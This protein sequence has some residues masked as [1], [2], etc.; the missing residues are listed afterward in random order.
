MVKGTAKIPPVLHIRFDGA[1]FSPETFYKSKDIERISVW[2]SVANFFLSFENHFVLNC[3]LCFIY[4][5]CKRSSK[6]C[7]ALNLPT[8]CVSCVLIPHFHIYLLHMS[9][10]MFCVV[11]S[12]GTTL[13]FTLVFAVVLFVWT[14]PASCH[15]AAS[16]LQV[17]ML[18]AVC[19][20]FWSILEWCHLY[21]WRFFWYEV[22]RVYRLLWI[23]L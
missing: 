9:M 6:I 14:P 3:T 4:L 2:F 17:S 8:L 1:G 16:A 12:S 22:I 15:S 5:P 21:L 20:S 23:L 18:L 7:F 11:P 13:Y 10:F 19:A